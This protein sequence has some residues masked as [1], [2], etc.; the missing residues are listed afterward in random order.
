[1]NGEPSLLDRFLEVQKQPSDLGPAS[2]ALK[3]L[4][5]DYVQLGNILI[6]S[7]H[8]DTVI[9]PQGIKNFQEVLIT[10]QRI[11]TMHYEDLSRSAGIALLEALRPAVASMSR[12]CPQSLDDR[13]TQLRHRMNDLMFGRVED[14]ITTNI[15]NSFESL[16]P[17]TNT[18]ATQ[19]IV[20]PS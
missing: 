17:P 13:E 4:V 1:M 7:P 15:L 16:K 18:A 20:D 19:A 6:R 5:A 14:S 10:S 2:D 11:L 8:V 3:T 9:T 12:G